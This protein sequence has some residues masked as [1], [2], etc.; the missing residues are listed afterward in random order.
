LRTSAIKG[1]DFP[2][3]ERNRLGRRGEWLVDLALLAPTL[4]FLLVFMGLPLV[5]VAI[6]GFGLLRMGGDSQFTLAF[7]EQILSDRIYRDSIVFSLYFSI[8]TT[9]LSLALALVL[10]AL[11][12]VNFPGR[13]VIS[14]LYKI[15]LV[16]PSLVAAFL[17]LT[18]IDQGGII[19]RVVSLHGMQVPDITHDRWGTG[20]I[21]VLVWHNVPIMI[22]IL[23]AIMASIPRDVLDA[24][25][26]LGA[27]PWQVFLNVTVPLSMSGISAASLLVFINVFGAFAVPSLIGPP[28]PSAVAVNMSNAIIQRGAWELASALG[29]LMAFASGAFLYGYYLLVRGQEAALQ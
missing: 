24:A 15:P 11:L 29:T 8:V 5:Q 13:S 23:S 9:I 4:G 25:R 27:T 2:T 22:V 6:R 18:L 10:S 12:Q 28:Y 17:V 16:V 7:Y 3:L 14:V 1:G 21:M 26:N 20:M 19:S